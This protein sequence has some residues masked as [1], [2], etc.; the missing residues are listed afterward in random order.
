MYFLTPSIAIIG[1][2]GYAL[3]NGNF[4]LPYLLFIL[5]IIVLLPSS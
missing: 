4:D 3:I 2:G 5:I 1:I